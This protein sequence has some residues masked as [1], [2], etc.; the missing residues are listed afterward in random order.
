[1]L[2]LQ[3]SQAFNYWQLLSKGS[4]SWVHSAGRGLPPIAG[5]SF[6]VWLYTSGGRAR[7]ALGSYGFWPSLGLFHWP[8]PRNGAFSDYGPIDLVY[9]SS[10]ASIKLI[11]AQKFLLNSTPVVSLICPHWYTPDD[12]SLPSCCGS[13]S[14]VLLTLQKLHWKCTV[15]IVH[16]WTLPLALLASLLPSSLFGVCSH[17]SPFARP[18][19]GCLH[20]AFILPASSMG[21]L[22]L[23][24]LGCENVLCKYGIGVGC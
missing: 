2:A 16:I 23:L 17:L 11:S 18:T 1:M 6:G 5:S 19:H 3:A 20:C 13:T 9:V 4:F 15:P 10:S 14:Q 8:F 21:V 7:K 24:K 22:H 12:S